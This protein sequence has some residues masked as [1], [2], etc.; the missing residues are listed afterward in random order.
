MLGPCNKKAHPGGNPKTR[1]RGSV[2]LFVIGKDAFNVFFKL[3]NMTLYQSPQKFIFNL[4]VGVDYS[5][6]SL[7][8]CPCIRQTEIR[9]SFQYA[10]YG[11]TH[12][13]HRTLNGTN[14]QTVISKDIKAVGIVGKEMFNIFTR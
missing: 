3:R 4:F 11:F 1:F 10:V 13:F 9:F 8:Y 12:Y 14:H 2:T 5:I 6:A 7:N